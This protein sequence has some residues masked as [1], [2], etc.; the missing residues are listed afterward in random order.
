MR[1]IG[2]IACSASKLKEAEANP[3]KEFPSCEMYTGWS[4]KKSVNEGL[5]EFRCDGYYILSDKYGLLSS[6]DPIK[7]YDSYLGGK[8]VA[9]RRKWSEKAY[10]KLQGKLG[11]LD[12]IEFIFFA[13]EKYYE[14][15]IKHLVH[16]KLLKYKNRMITFE[17]KA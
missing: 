10:N 14:H 5:K 17:V 3:C 7:Y 11:N 13:S 8:N 15:I 4:F 6:D 12:D 2:L 16:F 1:R 9:Y